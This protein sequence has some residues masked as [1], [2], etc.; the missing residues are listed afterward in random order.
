MAFVGADD[1]IL[2][3]AGDGNWTTE[4]LSNGRHPDKPVAGD[5]AFGARG[6]VPLMPTGCCIDGGAPVLQSARACQQRREAHR[7]VQDCLLAE[8]A[9]RLAR[10]ERTRDLPTR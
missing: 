2:G 5:E 9:N 3:A 4:P 7:W 1:M 8:Q 6:L 10:S